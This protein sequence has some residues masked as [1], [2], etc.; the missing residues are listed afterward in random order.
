MRVLY[1]THG[2]SDVISCLGHRQAT[3]NSVT[4]VTKKV[5]MRHA[6]GVEAVREGEVSVPQRSKVGVVIAPQRSRVG[7]A[8]V[9]G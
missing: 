8:T 6:V 9:Q 3:L 1:G 7:V 5:V 4:V 2:N